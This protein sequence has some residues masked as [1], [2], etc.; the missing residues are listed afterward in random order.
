MEKKFIVTLKLL[1]ICSISRWTFWIEP[2]EAPNY[3]IITTNNNG[4]K[5]KRTAMM[6]ATRVL[7]SLYGIAPEWEFVEEKPFE[8]TLSA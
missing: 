8:F 3:R 5:S 6:A 4:Y 1:S 2:V 7:S